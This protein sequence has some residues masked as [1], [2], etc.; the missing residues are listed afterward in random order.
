MTTALLADDRQSVRDA[1]RRR[2]EGDPD[3]QRFAADIAR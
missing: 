3:G 2:L 1:L